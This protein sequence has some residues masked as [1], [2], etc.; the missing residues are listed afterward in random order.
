M[1]WTY[2]TNIPKWSTQT[3][4]VN[5]RSQ[6]VDDG[7]P[8]SLPLGFLT[9]WIHRKRGKGKGG[10]EKHEK[11]KKKVLE[12]RISAW[13]SFW[14]IVWGWR[15][16]RKWWILDPDLFRDWGMPSETAP[17][18]KS[19][20]RLEDFRY[21][22]HLQCGVL[23]WNRI[24]KLKLPFWFKIIRLSEPYPTHSLELDESGS[25]GSQKNDTLST[26]AKTS[27]SDV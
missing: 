3:T 24:V 18:P 25:A 21:L 13:S 9:G 4:V 17:Q 10:K 16:G 1:N 5:C 14:T 12:L 22:D 2:C 27:W 8:I 23:S 26:S 11:L 15:C 7:M 19:S 6:L 20:D